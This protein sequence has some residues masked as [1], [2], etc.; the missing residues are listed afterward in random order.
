M[1]LRKMKT[2]LLGDP[3][4]SHAPSL[5]NFN[6]LALFEVGRTE[7]LKRLATFTAIM[8]SGGKG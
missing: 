5:T 6:Y 3:A 2:W 4:F 7:C 1:R 8:A